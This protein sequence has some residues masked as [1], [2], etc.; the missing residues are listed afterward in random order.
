M[1]A[2]VQ[3][4]ECDNGDSIPITP[5]SGVRDGTLNS[6][7]SLLNNQQSLF[8]NWTGS[9]ENIAQFLKSLLPWTASDLPKPVNARVENYFHS[10]LD[11]EK[12]F[13]AAADRNSEN[14]DR[15]SRPFCSHLAYQRVLTGQSLTRPR[16]IVDFIPFGFDVDKLIARFY[17]S[18]SFV[19]LY[20]IY[21]TEY[22][23]I[24]HQK[25]FYFLSSVRQL[26][27]VQRFLDKVLY[28]QSNSR[29]SSGLR[30]AV[31]V[32]L[33]AIRR[34]DTKFGELFGVEIFM[35]KDMVRQFKAYVLSGLLENQCSTF[36]VNSESHLAVIR[37]QLLSE[38]S[39]GNSSVY[40][41]VGPSG[42][43][44]V[45]AIQGD[46]DELVTH[47]A[48][49]ALKHCAIRPNV[50]S[51]HLPC[52]SFKSNY[53]WLQRTYDYGTCL[54][55]PVDALSKSDR[56]L[57]VKLDKLMSRYLWRLGPQMWS[58]QRMLDAEHNLRRVFPPDWCS[59]HMGL[60]ASSHMSAASDPVEFWLKLCGTTENR[61]ACHK[62]LSEKFIS[63][64]QSGSISSRLIYSTSILPWCHKRNY[65]IHVDNV[66]DERS[67][68]A[69][70]FSLPE[71]SILSF[72][73]SSSSSALKQAV[74]KAVDTS[75]P[76]AVRLSAESF[77][78]MYPDPASPSTGL[79]SKSWHSDWT[80][81]HCRRDERHRPSREAVES[82]TSA[83]GF[84]K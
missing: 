38:L 84:N 82:I 68:V 26:P 23:L 39:L 20:V 81:T 40:G 28:L 76:F 55:T 60:G 45:L 51:I 83:L 15:F 9:N 3:S 70:L 64:G 43:P 42:G 27:S 50:D 79:M 8:S 72:S 53:R 48:L 78:F 30:R 25:P 10:L 59:T 7:A 29:S 61:F 69:A 1:S 75:V 47:P 65:A 6:L 32:T 2:G 36:S 21:E 57:V 52:F 35:A 46:G 49:R 14:H 34:G 80:L 56:E 24:G 5:L 22:S 63:A 19:D 71:V 16:L 11:S 17:E 62:L 13:A 41:Q 4:R 31:N 54:S 77:P 73:N 74:K 18:Y 66:A 33:E 58:L 44:S 12:A 37:K 67:I